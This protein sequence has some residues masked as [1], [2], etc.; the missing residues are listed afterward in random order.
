MGAARRRVLGT[1]GLQSWCKA[2]G[3]VG[4][5]FAWGW[6]SCNQALQATAGHRVFCFVRS[7]LFLCFVGV[8]RWPTAPER[9]A[10][11][12]RLKAVNS[13]RHSSAW[14][15]FDR[16]A[17]A[18]R[19]SVRGGLL[20]SRAGLL[21]G[22]GRLRAPLARVTRRCRRPKA[23]GLLLSFIV[24]DSLL[25]LSLSLASGRLSLAVT[26]WPSAGCARPDGR[27]T[28]TAHACRCLRLNPSPGPAALLERRPQTHSPPA[29]LA[30]LLW[31]YFLGFS[32][33]IVSAARAASGDRGRVTGRCNRRRAR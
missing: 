23:A 14:C 21:G 32:S 3:V 16:A 25:C 4:F 24:G 2:E 11:T 29:R 20:Q 19:C 28:K 17:L 18:R 6:S 26:R 5:A 10:V 9:Q 30:R 15:C 12:R 13:G 33:G 27:T 7:L 22:L 8:L 31:C 1:G